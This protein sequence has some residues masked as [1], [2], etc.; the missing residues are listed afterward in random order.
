LGF[1][2]SLACRS[3][4]FLMVLLQLI[5]QDGWGAPSNQPVSAVFS[6]VNHTS[7]NLGF[8][9]DEAC[10]F[11]HMAGEVYKPSQASDAAAA[12][13]TVSFSPPLW[14]KKT[15]IQTFQLIPL[16]PVE[17][18]ESSHPFGP[19][20]ACL[21]CH[22]GALAAGIHDARLNHPISLAYPRQPDGHF[23][24]R[25]NTPNLLRYWSIPD[26]TPSGVI[27]P[28]GPQSQYFSLPTGS[29]SGDLSVSAT[30]VRTTLGYI[31]CDSCHNPHDNSTAPFLRASSKTLCLICHD[32]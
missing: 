21:A 9:N 24:P 29:N 8:S 7:H 31:H 15:S 5:S 32:R 26:R 6:S 18:P 10:I 11:C 16:S 17:T 23:V 27:L 1:T 19:S 25:R 2:A 20:S 4:L 14:D 3:A 12:P 30:V 28:T 22:D 13:R